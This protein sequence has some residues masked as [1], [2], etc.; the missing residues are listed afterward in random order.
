MK[1]LSFTF[2][3]I[4]FLAN[5]LSWLMVGYWVFTPGMRSCPNPSWNI[6]FLLWSLGLVA[7]LVAPGLAFRLGSQKTGALMLAFTFGS[8]MLWVYYGQIATPFY[9]GG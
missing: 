6:F 9:C 2:F 3:T 7:G 1:K 8:L 4:Q 5:L